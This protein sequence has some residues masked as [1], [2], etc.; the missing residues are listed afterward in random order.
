MHFKAMTDRNCVKSSSV[1]LRELLTAQT[2]GG[3]MNGFSSRPIKVSEE[4]ESEILIVRDKK[5]FDCRFDFEKRV[6]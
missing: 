2:T 4:E 1:Q 5:T 6:E 3:L